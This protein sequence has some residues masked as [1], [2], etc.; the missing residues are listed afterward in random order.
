MPSGTISRAKPRQE[1]LCAM[2]SV[3]TARF[4]DEAEPADTEKAERPRQNLDQAANGVMVGSRASGPIAS[5]GAGFDSAAK[6]DACLLK[7]GRFRPRVVRVSVSFV[8]GFP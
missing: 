4:G 2:I 8:A 5:R 3:K 1:G 7:D 6:H